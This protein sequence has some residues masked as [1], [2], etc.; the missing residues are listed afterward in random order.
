MQEDCL[1]YLL[2]IIPSQGVYI[3]A[4]K[5]YIVEFHT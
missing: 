4:V 5:S 3:L 1:A 2:V